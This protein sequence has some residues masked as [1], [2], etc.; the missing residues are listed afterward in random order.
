MRS[1]DTQRQPRNAFLLKGT[2]LA[3]IC[4]LLTATAFF[5]S[6]RHSRPL[7][8]DLSDCTCIEVHYPYGGIG[9]FLRGQSE[10]I[11]SEEEKQYLRSLG[12]RTVTD[13]ELIQ[14]LARD[15][16][17]GR[18]RGKERGWTSHGVDLV[19]YRDDGVMISLSCFGNR[20]VTEDVNATAFEYPPDLPNLEMLEPASVQPL[21]ARWT[22]A[23]HLNY[24]DSVGLRNWGRG[25]Q[26]PDPNKWCDAIAEALQSQPNNYAN[27]RDRKKRS[28]AY[29]YMAQMFTC[30]SL[31][32]PGDPNGSE[33]SAELMD[34]ERTMRSWRSDYA[35]NPNCRADSPKDMVFL[36]ESKPGWNQHGG[37]EL[38]TFDNHDP[39]GGLILLNDGE[40][41]FIRTEEKLRQLRWR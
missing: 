6:R 11:L 34:F 36:F 16:R 5:L 9:Y 32:W 26:Y 1:N 19:C 25:R 4:V 41:K 18:Y 39:K 23:S 12:V 15:I 21:R 31:R 35:M 10:A 14:A 33:P 28:R 2:V 20:I 13:P 38:F 22:C 40:V 30:P 3:C 29:A 27:S 7:P 8:P 17:R 24:L 37:P